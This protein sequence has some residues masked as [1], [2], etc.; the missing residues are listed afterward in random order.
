M[1]L[2]ICHL[3]CYLKEIQKGE[4]SLKNFWQYSFASMLDFSADKSR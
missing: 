2:V 1:Y 3:I 4:V